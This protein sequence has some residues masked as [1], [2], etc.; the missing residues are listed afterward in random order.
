MLYA[1][2]DVKLVEWSAV[3]QHCLTAPA[4]PLMLSVFENGVA[5]TVEIER[6]AGS[7]AKMVEL[8][9]EGR[10]ERVETFSRVELYPEKS[11]FPVYKIREPPV[12]KVKEVGS[13]KRKLSSTTISARKKKSQT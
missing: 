9:D 13:N 7:P 5:G 12:L 6:P 4:L 8:D 1:P 3:E 2:E 11:R 10:A